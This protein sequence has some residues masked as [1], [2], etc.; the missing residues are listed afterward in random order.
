MKTEFTNRFYKDIEKLTVQ[1]V[2][3]DIADA[4]ENVELAT[5]I[6]EIRK[7][8]KLKGYSFCYR[9]RIGNY[10]IGVFIENDVVEFA[11]VAHRKDLYSTFP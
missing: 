5:K 10:R 8:K 1:S 11:R 3:D 2:K 6:S 9:I 4:I 7:I